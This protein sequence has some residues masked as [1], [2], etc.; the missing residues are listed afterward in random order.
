[1]NTMH[2]SSSPPGNNN[3]TAVIAKINRSTNTT[4]AKGATSVEHC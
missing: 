4:I 1:M 3:Q 2:I